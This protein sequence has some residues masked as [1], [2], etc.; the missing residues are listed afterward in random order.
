M[1]AIKIFS[2]VLLGLCMT[3]CTEFIFEDTQPKDFKHLTTFPEFL[4]GDFV[5]LN[6]STESIVNPISIGFLDQHTIEILS[7]DKKTSKYDKCIFCLLYTS[8]S[9]RDQRGS[10]MP[11]SA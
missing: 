4:A 8:P 11:S 10:R 6:D 1:K 2:I 9:P 3:S 5:E 7:Y